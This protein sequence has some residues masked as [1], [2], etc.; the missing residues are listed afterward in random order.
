MQIYLYENPYLFILNKI[1][2]RQKV[3]N[4]HIFK[5]IHY[6]EFLLLN[7]SSIA[8]QSMSMSISLAG[9]VAVG[10]NKSHRPYKCLDRRV[11]T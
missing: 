5:V 2:L 8:C 11:E 3:Q 10:A 1:K 6:V 7:I 4:I 9:A